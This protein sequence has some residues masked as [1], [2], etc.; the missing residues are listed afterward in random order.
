MRIFGS[1]G[2]IQ[3]LASLLIVAWLLY[4]QFVLGHSVF[5]MRPLLYF[6]LGL[7]LS[8]LIFVFMGFLAELIVSIRDDIRKMKDDWGKK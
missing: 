4:G 8:G 1:F 2:F 3:L 6:S 7:F 5:R